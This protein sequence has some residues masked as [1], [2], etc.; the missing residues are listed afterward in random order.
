[1]CGPRCACGRAGRRSPGSAARCCWGS[2]SSLQ[3]ASPRR[4]SSHSNPTARR[5][6][7]S[8]TTPETARRPRASTACRATIPGC[9]RT[10]RGSAR[11]SPAISAR[12]SPMPGRRHRSWP[13]T[14]ASRRRKRHSRAAFSSRRISS[15]RGVWPCRPPRNCHLRWRPQPEPRPVRYRKTTTLPS[16][17]APSTGRR[18]APTASMRRRAA[19]CCRPVR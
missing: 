19:M 12:R 14:P 11:R 16:S 2:A 8:S 7:A 18:S 3:P 13:Q 15:S 4:F 17:T 1:M 6:A 5:P 9:R 10:C